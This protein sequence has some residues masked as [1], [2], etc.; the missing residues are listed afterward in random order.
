MTEQFEASSPQITPSQ[1]Q[2]ILDSADFIIFSTDTNGVIQ[3]LNTKALK[4]LGYASVE[5][6]GKATPSIFHDPVEV[7]QRAQA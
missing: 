6:I 1:Q 3:T 4:K 2:S 7:E 5:I